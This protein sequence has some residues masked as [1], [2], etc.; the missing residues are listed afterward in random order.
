MNQLGLLDALQEAPD[1]TRLFEVTNVLSAD[2]I[3]ALFEPPKHMNQ[4]QEMTHTFFK[5]FLHEL[6]KA[7][8]DGECFLQ[9]HL[10]CRSLIP[11]ID[12]IDLKTFENSLKF[13]FQGLLYSLNFLQSAPRAWKLPEFHRF[14]RELFPIFARDRFCFSLVST[15]RK[16]LNFFFRKQWEPCLLSQFLKLYF[17]VP[18]FVASRNILVRSRFCLQ[19]TSSSFSFTIRKKLS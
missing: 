2:Y 5:N 13:F 14:W 17:K 4:E 3:I 1:A 18:Q 6:E 7:E 9:F 10:Y 8:K 15:P 12:F 19:Y 16:L 11:L